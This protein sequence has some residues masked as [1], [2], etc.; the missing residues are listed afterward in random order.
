MYCCQ[1]LRY[2]SPVLNN[3]VMS[4]RLPSCICSRIVVEQSV[5]ISTELLNLNS[6][7]KDR[8]GDIILIV[9][10][11]EKSTVGNNLCTRGG[12]EIEV[13]TYDAG[14]E[15]GDICRSI[16]DA[17]LRVSGRVKCEDALRIPWLRLGHRPF[18]KT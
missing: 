16:H 10:S 1:L 12:G 5:Q 2:K 8:I 17:P 11:I 3:M 9:T 6:F 15:F 13:S 7:P 14:E 4:S 18:C